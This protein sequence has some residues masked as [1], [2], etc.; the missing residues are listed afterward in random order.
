[1]RGNRRLGESVDSVISNVKNG[2]YDSK[3]YS[4][5]LHKIC[6]VQP[7]I[8]QTHKQYNKVWNKETTGPKKI[9]NRMLL[10]FQIMKEK[11]RCEADTKTIEIKKKWF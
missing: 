5:L 6:N 4:V 8:I 9:H 1:M 2:A 11:N 7:F 10:F 3:Q